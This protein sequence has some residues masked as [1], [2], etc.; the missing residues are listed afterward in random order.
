MPNEEKDKNKPEIPK[1]T[2]QEPKPKP[3]Q[4]RKNVPDKT[5]KKPIIRIINEER[6]SSDK[7]EEY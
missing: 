1:K 3:K 6:Q 7:K 2:Q 4:K 5:V